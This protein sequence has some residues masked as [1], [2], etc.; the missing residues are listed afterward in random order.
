MSVLRTVL[1][2][3]VLLLGSVLAL[4]GLGVLELPAPLLGREAAA[5]RSRSEDL[6]ALAK[7]GDP[8]AVALALEE[9]APVSARDAFGQTPLMY[10]A[11]AG[12]SPEVLEVL[13]E[14][15]AELNAQT[16]AGW[17]A[18]MYA[19]RDAPDLDV[20]LWLMNAGA[21][22]TLRNSDGQSA[23]DL[24]RENPAMSTAL[25][26]RLQE[27]S[28]GPFDPAWPSGYMVPVEGATVSSRINHLPGAPRA[29]RNGTHEGF[30]FYAGSVSVPIE[31]GTPVRA[32]AP[33]TVI[34][35]DHDYVENDVAAYEAIIEAA[36]RSLNTPAELLDQLRGRQV[37][38]EHAGGFVSRY[39]HL[40]SV[41]DAVQ[42]G[43]RVAQGEVVAATG[44]SGTLEAAQNTQADPHPHVEIWR[45]GTYLG[46]D[47]SPEAIYALAGQV[48]GEEARPPYF[49]E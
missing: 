21:D 17:T 36:R 26:A 13:L 19:A 22:P 11:S 8:G 6:F 43:A 42:V 29:Y 2:A 45:D 4:W 15:G 44:N 3:V 1:V 9:G 39:A 46:K 24:A 28:D 38:V 34:R 18:L 48:F 10:A 35:A 12:D 7:G 31:Y 32:V 41:A 47:L 49:G 30:D 33:G 5:A 37:W 23:A 40:S 14:A 20:P 16:D 27:L 25:F